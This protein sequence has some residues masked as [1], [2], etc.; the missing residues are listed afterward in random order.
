MQRAL[1]SRD[2]I[3][4]GEQSAWPEHTINPCIKRVTVYDIHRDMLRP[5]EIKIFRPKRKF[6]GVT[7][8]MRH[9]VG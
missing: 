4:H 7:G 8:H 2:H 5:G 1:L 3:E 9:A 6:R